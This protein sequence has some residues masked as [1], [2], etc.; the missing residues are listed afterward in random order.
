MSKLFPVLT[1][2]LFF[3]GCAEKKPF[4]TANQINEECTLEMEAARTAV[5]L[6]NDGMSRDDLSRTL[7][8]LNKDS[9]RLLVFMHEILGE[10]YKYKDLNEVIYPTYRFELCSRQLTNK[11]YP[12]TITQIYPALLA[13]QSRFGKNAS[14]DATK[15][16]LSGFQSG[17]RSEK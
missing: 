7:P 6:R 9:S 10:V 1:L 11:P 16:V 17:N 12:Y 2:L 8:P 4:T 5:L 3:T 13:C 14:T 15:C